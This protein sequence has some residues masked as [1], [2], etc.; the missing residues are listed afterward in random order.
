[1]LWRV[2][3]DASMQNR[4]TVYSYCLWKIHRYQLKFDKL[5]GKN[6]IVI[7]ESWLLICSLK[8]KFRRNGIRQRNFDEVVTVCQFYWECRNHKCNCISLKGKNPFDE[9]S[10]QDKMFYDHLI[11]GSSFGTRDLGNRISFVFLLIK[12]TVLLQRSF[13]K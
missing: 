8:Y 5:Y 6:K 2:P 9:I 12:K 1:M 13:I 11:R 4:C 7:D 10:S 3:M